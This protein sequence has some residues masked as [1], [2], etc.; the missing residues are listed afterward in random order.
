MLMAPGAVCPQAFATRLAKSNCYLG[1]ASL[2]FRDREGCVTTNKKIRSFD[3]ARVCNA[4]PEGPHIYMFWTKKSE[5]R[6]A[7]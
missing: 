7:A 5:L 6:P 2:C 1:D 4:S 3:R